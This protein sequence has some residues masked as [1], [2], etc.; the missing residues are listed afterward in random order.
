VTYP[1][2]TYFPTSAPPPGWVQ[3]LVGVVGSHED[4]IDSRKHRMGSD[5]VLKVVAGD[6]KALGY[7]LELSKARADKIRRPVLFGPQGAEVVAYE[8]DAFHDEI[9]VV[10]EI[11]AGRGH[12]GNALFRDLVRTSLI[13]G[14]KY[15]AIGMCLEYRFKSGGKVMKSADYAWALNEVGAIY[16]SGRL[17]LPFEG[18][19]VFGY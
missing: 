8:I 6:L 5:D 14:A 11:E 19:L 13:V 4:E 17:R 3:D 10:L 1:E 2:W 9:G 18:V 16:A 15:L 7:A 12:L